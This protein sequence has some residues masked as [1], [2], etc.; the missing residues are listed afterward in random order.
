MSDA[1]KITQATETLTEVAVNTIGQNG[2]LSQEVVVKNLLEYIEYS[3]NTTLEER[4]LALNPAAFVE[5]VK[6]ASNTES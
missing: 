4:E 1:Q 3:I 2:Y 5:R 6:G